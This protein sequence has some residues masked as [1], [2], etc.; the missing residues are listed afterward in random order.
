M[1]ARRK[2]Q[3][4]VY[5]PVAKAFLTAYP[6][7]QFPGC[8]CLSK[9]VHHKRGRHGSLLMDTNYWMAVCR[10]HHRWIGGNP[11]AAL[12]LGLLGPWGRT[13]RDEERIASGRA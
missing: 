10:K 3:Y 4:E 5:K 1:S 13:A 2:E 12:E 6:I 7:C 11:K 8:Q 9:D